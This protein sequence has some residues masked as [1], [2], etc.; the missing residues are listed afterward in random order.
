MRAHV[1]VSLSLLLAGAAASQT[2]SPAIFMD[3]PVDV[4]H[5]AHMTV[6]RIPTHGVRIN[7]IIY[8]AAGA[9]LHP[10]LV[11][12]HGLP[13]NEKNL[14]IAQAARRAGWNSVT[15]NYRGSWGSPG[16]F[17][18]SQNL[19][20]ADAVLAYLRDPVN[21]RL[22]GVDTNRLVIAGH[23]MG[24]WVAVN[25]ASRDRALAGLITI[26]A[27]DLSKQGEWPRDKLVALMTDCMGPLAGVTPESMANEARAL[28]KSLRFDAA[29]AG[30]TE[31]P[32]LALTADDG[33]A[34]DTDSLVRAIKAGG[35]HKVTTMH[36]S[37]DHNWSDRRVA[38]QD[39][40]LRWL[41]ARAE[42]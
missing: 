25:T 34:S 19:E 4:A 36:A 27:A 29:A 22:L 7:G 20:D 2:V 6:L 39:V 40:I 38:L 11:I 26:S 31:M 37:T 32:L 8:Q 9:G 10:T 41:A 5:P 24:G 21:A 42:K 17:S 30:L 1:L 33:L 23:S 15:F 16:N 13:G 18:F 28:G 14:D 3:P 35:G 12:C